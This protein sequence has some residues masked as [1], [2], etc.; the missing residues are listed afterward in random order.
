MLN[1]FTWEWFKTALIKVLRDKA[2]KSVLKSVLGSA[3]AGGVKGW[4][5]KY[6]ATELFDEVAKPFMQYV[7]RKAGYVYDVNQGDH[8]LK[9]IE[10]AETRDDWRTSVNDA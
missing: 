1:S 5:I 8:T 3:S 4:I 7:F 6:I 10:N 2:V 9:R